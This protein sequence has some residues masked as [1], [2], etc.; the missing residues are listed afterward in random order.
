V[1]G[2]TS[3]AIVNLTNSQVLEQYAHDEIIVQDWWSPEGII[4][5]DLRGRRL[6]V[7]PSTLKLKPAAA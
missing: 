2:E 1:I 3:V 6:L 5:E 7:E 4:L